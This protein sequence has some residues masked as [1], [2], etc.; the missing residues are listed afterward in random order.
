MEYFVYIMT[1]KSKGTLYIGITN[2]L[3]RRVYEH[4]N[5]LT[6]GF[7]KK[8]KIKR[9]VHFEVFDYVHNALQREKTLKHWKRDWKIRLIEELNPQWKDLWETICS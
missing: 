6:D 3:I 1:N 9:L 8:Y 4:K 2:N 5:E 7:T